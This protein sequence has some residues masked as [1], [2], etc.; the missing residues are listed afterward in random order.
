MDLVKGL[1]FAGA[2]ICATLYSAM[3]LS[4]H[5]A[6]GRF[7]THSLMELEGTVT[8]V[9]WI[10][11]HIY[12]TL[13]TENENG[14]SEEWTLEAG[15][16]GFL[17]RAGIG[18]D[19]INAGDNIRVAGWPPL[20]TRKELFVSNVLTP[21]GDELLFI[22]SSRPF[23]NT[24]GLGDMSYLFAEDGDG[25][26]PELGIF[27]VWSH[28]FQSP[29]LYPQT[30]DPSYDMSNFPLTDAAMASV[31]SYDGITDNPTRNCTPKGMPLIME[32]PYPL[33]F[34][35]EGDRILVRIEEY[36]QVRTIHMNPDAASAERSGTSLGY[37]IGRWED[38][39]TLVVE[40]TDMNWGWFDQQGTPLSGQ[41]V[42]VERV[43]VSD[44]G[45][46]LDY[47]VTTTDPA[48]FTEPVTLE[49]YWYYLP[50]MDV[51]T[52]DCQVDESEL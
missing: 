24:E 27:R 35:D 50:G 40:T 1:V 49:K 51:E 37:S 47:V 29:F 2:L 9:S 11:P 38:A 32:Q 30:I 44:D 7:D 10:N 13:E 5:S 18:R 3:V 19:A 45:S 16:P 6:A 25:S 14:E 15:S 34:V 23:W 36:D 52:Y 17:S 48:N 43:E 12:M 22:S 42:V 21:A 20:T 41:A 8:R 39:S 46:R 31:E 28:T 4:H 26:Q 33:E